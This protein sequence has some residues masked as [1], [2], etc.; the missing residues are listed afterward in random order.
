MKKISKVLVIVLMIIGMSLS[1]YGC[2]AKM[3][4]KT[5]KST[6]TIIDMGGCEVVIPKE[7]TRVACGSNPGM[8]MMIAFGAGDKLVAAHKTVFDNPWFYKFYP[9][10]G[11]LLKIDSYEPEAESLLAMDVDI[12]FLPDPSVCEALRQ[13]GVCAVCLRVYNSEEVKRAASLLGEVF[14]G[15]VAE[16]ATQW[17]EAFDE[18]IKDIDKRLSDIPLE[19]RPV[20]YEII[21]AKYKG[22]YRTNYGDAQAWIQYGGGQIA[23][24]EFAGA[25]WGNMPTEEA[26]LSTNPEVVLISGIYWEQLKREL[27]ADKKWTTIPAIINEQVYNI[28]MGCTDWN[29]YSTCYPL[30]NYF[31]FSVLYPEKVDFSLNAMA[32]EFYL[33]YYEIEFSDEEIE[34]MMKGLS[35]L[36]ESTCN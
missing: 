7:I 26:I 30:M 28:P 15:K 6:R 12:I 1:L 27:Y 34:F 25:T 3:P 14:G 4:E 23:T 19:E 11:E 21:G 5:S 13:K 35:P 31:V 8:D 33:D 36:G 2:S 16:K 22:I 24:L 18:S 32:K 20:V 9:N 29:N 17:L 10:A